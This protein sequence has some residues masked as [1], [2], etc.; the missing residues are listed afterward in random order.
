MKFEVYISC[1]NGDTIIVEDE[2]AADRVEWGTD[3]ILRLIYE[4]QVICVPI[5]NIIFYRVTEV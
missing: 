1:K 2:K 4:H 5:E 3:R